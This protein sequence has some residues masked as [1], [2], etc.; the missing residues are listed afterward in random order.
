MSLALD[1]LESR[2]LGRPRLHFRPEWIALGLLVLVDVVWSFAAGFHFRFGVTDV[3][4]PLVALA[5]AL[6]LRALDR[7][8]IAALIGEYLA[9]TLFAVIALAVLTYLCCAV[10]LPRVDDALLRADH[11]LGFDWLYWFN[12]L[13]THHALKAVLAWSYASMPYQALYFGVLFGMMNKSARLREMF[14]IVMIGAVVTSIGSVAMP[15]LGPFK[16][17]GLERSGDFVA[18]MEQLRHRDHLDF[19]I[20]TLTG[21]VSF[22]SFHTMMA[23]TYIYCFRGTGWIGHGT[24]LINVVMLAGVPFFGGH[25]LVDMLAGAVVA[26]VV[27]AVARRIVAGV[28]MASPVAAPDR[29][30]APRPAG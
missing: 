13:Q 8:E 18:V 5:I 10:G 22:P 1:Y 19:A 11:A 16:I 27:I 30:A 20:A 6:G 26:A 29:L 2:A 17:Y 4:V 24:G 15:A 9:L 7:Y 12:W 3:S 14:W 23:L 28:E 25:Y 21:V